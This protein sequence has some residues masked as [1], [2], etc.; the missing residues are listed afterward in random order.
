M[1]IK[2]NFKKF[3]PNLNKDFELKPLQE[4][5]ISSV[6]NKQNTLVIMPTG[7]GKSLIYWISGL[8]LKGIT[9]VI[10][11]LIALI[12]EQAEKL[13]NHGYKVLSLHGDIKADQQMNMLTK[14]Y[15]KKLNPNFIFVSPERIATDGF[16]EFVL[17]CR[18]NEIK[19]FTI[20][21]AH[22]ISQWGYD[23]RPF[24]KRIPQFIDKVF[25]GEKPI[26]LALTATINPKDIEEI[27]KD[28]E[29]DSILKDDYL[30]RSEISLNV[31]KLS[32][33]NQK[34]DK[35]WQL[36]EIHKSSKTIVYLYRKYH[37]RGTEDL[38]K[39]AKDRGFNAIN[40]HGDMSSS[41]R[42]KIISD[43]KEGNYNLIFATN[44]FGMGIDIPDIRVSI[45]FMIPESVEQY[46]QEVGR[47]ARDGKSAISYILYTNKN[48]DIRKSHFIDKSFLTIDDL[49]RIHKRITN[50]ELGLKTLQYF[51][52]EEVQHSLTYFLDNGIISI[53]SK[54]FTNLDN[55]SNVKLKSINLLLNS[56]KT[57][58]LIT[59]VKKT[60][61][62]VNQ[63]VKLIYTAVVN[64]NIQL[65]KPFNKCL[66]IE[67]NFKTL[68]EEV[69]NKIQED[70]NKKKAYKYDMLD[71]LKYI[72]DN[73]ES[74]TQLHQEIGLYLG[75]E[76][77]QLG[78]I[79]KTRNGER[80]R[81]KSEL[82]IA[83]LLYEFN[84]SYEYEKKLFY[85][86]NKWIEPD[87]TINNGK[88]FYWEHL[89]MRGIENYDS[90]WL[91][92]L[93]IY[94]KYFS[95]RLKTTFESPDLTDAALKVIKEL[96]RNR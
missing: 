64:G 51:E 29:I 57:K 90:K 38:L 8:S 87:F 69:I 33:E 78:K 41:E 77:R 3:F 43:F 52:D 67:N 18:S 61:M 89:G 94:Q 17:K 50:N 49:H 81:S 74:S 7:G 59:T 22:C 93:N 85:S 44:A 27:K 21:E 70:I 54:G 26:I 24:Y 82:I 76:K 53:I 30:L 10:S 58:S 96:K 60:K 42:K 47:I 72:L 62:P 45:H 14:F 12:D 20:D 88:E 68:N 16:F 4:K 37:K 19:L 39:K 34:E 86:K 36:L 5:A 40:F 65:S 75:M 66:I 83:N 1:D 91:E 84:I 79:Y 71:Y 25:D 95:G 31:I 56:T 9:I 92:K 35:L 28:F 73:T 11:P 55:L 32:D 13:I 48:V 46:Y 63:I 80:V 2:N 15:H 23:F 6:L